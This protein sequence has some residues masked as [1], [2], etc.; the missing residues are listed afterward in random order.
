M[1]SKIVNIL[2]LL[3]LII[4]NL[5]SQNI[6]INRLNGELDRQINK[7]NLS[8]K[9]EARVRR[10]VVELRDFLLNNKDASLIMDELS[11]TY[12]ISGKGS[13]RFTG[14]SDNVSSNWFSGRIKI[15]NEKDVISVAATV[16]DN[17]IKSLGYLYN[18]SK[19]KT[20]APPEYSN[21]KPDLDIYIQKIMFGHINN[22]AYQ[23]SKLKTENEVKLFV[24]DAT[25][26]CIKSY[27]KEIREH[28]LIIDTKY[29]NQL[30]EIE[31]AI[32]YKDWDKFLEASFKISWSPQR[33]LLMF[34]E[35]N[36]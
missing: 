18:N 21:Y 24:M 27:N 16:Y 10:A 22:F 2:I 11:G 6:D 25:D 28:K 26:K 1:K 31:K 12:R 33:Y 20:N 34:Y 19:N 35:I 30:F 32:S 23:F 9:D 3:F 29:I 13:E 5:A 36:R 14:S 7:F 17:A 8:S 15:R 4:Y